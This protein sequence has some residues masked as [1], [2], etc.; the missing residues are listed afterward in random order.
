MRHRRHLPESM[1]VTPMQQEQHVATAVGPQEVPNEDEPFSKKRCTNGT[2]MTHDHTK[3]CC[4]SS[5]GWS[6]RGSYLRLLLVATLPFSLP[7]LVSFV[8]LRVAR[9]KFDDRR[10]HSDAPAGAERHSILMETT[11]MSSILSLQQQTTAREAAELSVDDDPEAGGSVSQRRQPL[12]ILHIGPYKTATTSLQCYF[13]AHT[14]ALQHDGIHYVGNVPGDVM[15]GSGAGGDEPPVND[16]T[17]TA[18]QQDR[19]SSLTRPVLFRYC[20]DPICQTD[21]PVEQCDCSRAYEIFHN[22]T[23][24]HFANN[25]T[26]LIS[27]EMFSSVEH[28]DEFVTQMRHWP[29]R[30]VFTYRRLYEGLPSAYYQ[31]YDTYGS[32]PR[33]HTTLRQWPDEGGLLIPTVD[34]Y[35]GKKWADVNY[36]PSAKWQRWMKQSHF[37][38]I[39]IA[40]M[41]GANEHAFLHYFVC[42][43]L[44]EA[45]ELCRLM[46]TSSDETI[47][48][49]AASKQHLHWDHLAVA[50]YQKGWINGGTKNNQDSN[51]DNCTAATTTTVSRVAARE[52]L[53]R[54]YNSIGL[55]KVGDFNTTCVS[56]TNMDMLLNR[57]LQYEYET[58]PDFF[59]SALGEPILR[60]D[61]TKSRS[62]TKFCSIDVEATLGQHHDEWWRDFFASIIV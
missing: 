49:T 34:E 4:S 35:L 53:Q 27:E 32:S 11:T 16:Q 23:N 13:S 20:L 1:M 18:I 21:P 57:S 47:V 51:G 31:I 44:H 29:I 55:Y 5:S 40:N 3:I 19:P 50:A 6:A 54:Y 24:I 58:L 28:L 41:H 12:F 33:A 48:N 2:T 7:S 62:K 22:R 30:V 37:H 59:H 26:I 42:D 36:S 39:T 14:A 52:A 45:K 17:T 46:S 9:F 43:I 15:C 25:E 10:H 60:S 8:L 56:E 38:D 61:F